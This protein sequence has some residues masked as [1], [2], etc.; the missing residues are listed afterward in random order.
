MDFKTSTA[1]TATTVAADALLV[2]VASAEAAAAL[3]KPLAD[4]FARAL[5]DG[6]LDAKPAQV[7]YAHRVAGVKAARVLKAE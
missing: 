6:D 2:I 3:E 4:E 5:R 7:L 1:G